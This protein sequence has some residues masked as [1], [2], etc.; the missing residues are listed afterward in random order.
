MNDP[1]FTEDYGI[2]KQLDANLDNHLLLVQTL[3]Q[4]AQ[5]AGL[6]T[7]AVGKSGPA[8][9]Q[10]IKNGGYII[11]EKAA[12]PLSFAKEL[13][14]AHIALPETTPYAYRNGEL[15]LADDNGDPTFNLPTQH[16]DDRVTPNPD[17]NHGAPPTKANRI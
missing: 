7:A 5:K 2:L 1:V 15:K 12:F 8:F 10:D 9:M 11:D 6:V 17:D 13:Q 4:T 16:L 14:A 3:L